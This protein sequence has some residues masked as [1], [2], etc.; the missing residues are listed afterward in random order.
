[1]NINDNDGKFFQLL[2]EYLKTNNLTLVPNNKRKVGVTFCDTD[3]QSI[4]DDYN[5][6]LNPDQINE[7]MDIVENISDAEYGTSWEEIR[8]AIEMWVGE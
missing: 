7:V 6:V 3:I 4:A 8:R 1:M 5:L 2:R